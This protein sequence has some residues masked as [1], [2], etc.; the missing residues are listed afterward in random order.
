MIRRTPLVALAAG[1]A[2]LV[3]GQNQANE[4]RAWLDAN[5][6]PAALNVT[7]LWQGGE[8]GRISL[9]QRDGGRRIIGTG[10]GWD[11]SGVVSGNNVCLLFFHKEKIA[12]S[13]KITAESPALLTGVYAS[14]LLS[15]NS[16]TRPMR[17]SK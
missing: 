9:N 11:I 5:Q 1:W 3:F 15:S 8:W 17:L 10:D 6:E 7:G 2:A 16:K 4:G 12:Y 13:A 14:G